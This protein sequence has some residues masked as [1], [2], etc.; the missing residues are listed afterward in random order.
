MANNVQS[1]IKHIIQGLIFLLLFGVGLIGLYKIFNWKDTTGDYYSSMEQMYNLPDNTVD[2]AFFGPSVM[3][4]GINPAVL[5][6]EQGI[7]SFNAAISGQD[8][9]ASYY[10]IREFVKK[11][12]PKVVFVSGM[13]FQNENYVVQGNLYRNTLSMKTSQNYKELVDAVVPDNDMT[14]TNTV[15]DYYLRWPIIHSR[16]KE[17]KKN[18]FVPVKEYE[19]WLGYCYS[20]DGTGNPSEDSYFDTS[21]ASPITEANKAWVDKLYELSKEEN[22]E[23]VFLQLPGYIDIYWRGKLNGDFAYLDELGIKHLDLNMCADEI[24][25]DYIE[26][27]SDWFHTKTP[28]ATKLSSYVAGYIKDNLEYVDRRGEV[29][30]ELYDESVEVYHHE[31][32]ANELAG[33][34]DVTKAFKMIKGV[35]GIMFSVTLKNGASGIGTEAAV[36]IKANMPIRDFMDYSGTS[37][38]RDG[39]ATEVLGYTEYAVKLNDTEYMTVKPVVTD[40]GRLDEVHYGQEHCAGTDDNGN[41]M[42]IYDTLLDRVVAVIDIH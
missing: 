35:D 16:Y 39:Y 36:A 15:W 26:D 6:E 24:G 42:A 2:V 30:Y 27:M 20:F 4:S 37:V 1:T 9:E 19:K 40:D 22:F 25:F 10:F 3:Y 23:L 38:V 18:D 14:E 34:E 41:F 33:C 12:S 5:W 21:E 13:L 7:A 29:G 28:G 31:L 17:I 11:Q 8:R 32:I